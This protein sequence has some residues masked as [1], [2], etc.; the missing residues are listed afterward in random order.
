[1]HSPSCRRDPFARF[2]SHRKHCDCNLLVQVPQVH[3][4]PMSWIFSAE[5][6]GLL[7]D[8]Y[9]SQVKLIQRHDVFV[10]LNEEMKRDAARCYNRG[11]VPGKGITAGR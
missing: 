4:A 7:A 3:R 1:M 5:R 9:Q 6:V 8:C 11:Q 10:P 2:V